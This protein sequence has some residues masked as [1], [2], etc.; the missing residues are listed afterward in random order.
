MIEA[1]VMCAVLAQPM[2]MADWTHKMIGAQPP[3]VVATEENPEGFD[4]AD[5]LYL[6]AHWGGCPNT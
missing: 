6:L 2:D 3:P 1:F 5:F 4:V